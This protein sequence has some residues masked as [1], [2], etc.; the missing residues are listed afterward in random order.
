MDCMGMR[1]NV[2]KASQGR[3]KRNLPSRCSQSSL[4]LSAPRSSSARGGRSVCAL[5]AT[6]GALATIAGLGR[7][8]SCSTARSSQRSGRW[9]CASCAHKTRPAYPRSPRVQARTETCMPLCTPCL[10]LPPPQVLLVG[11]LI[12]RPR[13]C[14][15]GTATGKS[16]VLKTRQIADVHPPLQRTRTR[17]ITRVSPETVKAPHARASSLKNN[18]TSGS[19]RAGTQRFGRA[20]TLDVLLKLNSVRL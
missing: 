12:L 8:G 5:V 9:V 1:A 16:L 14:T 20:A 15:R 13:A 7:K 11:R 18:N 17:S 4:S 3:V 2:C 6:G 10:L 19:R